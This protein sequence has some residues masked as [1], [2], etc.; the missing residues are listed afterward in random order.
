V[1]IS[2]DGKRVILEARGDLFFIDPEKKL[3]RNLTDTPGTTE[4]SPRWS[5]NGKYYAYI[6]D[7]SG[8]EQIYVCEI[9]QNSKSSRRLTDC[10][11]T[12][13]AYISWS[14]D[15]KTIG[16]SSHRSTYF[17]TEVA[18]TVSRKVFF[19]KYHGSD[20]YVSAAWSPDSRWLAFSKANNQSWF[21][22]I[23]LY[24]LETGKT[25]RVTGDFTHDDS[26]RFDPRGR[27]LFW[28]TG[29]DVNVESSYWDSNHF[30]VNPSKIIAAAL[31]KDTFAPFTQQEGKAG[32]NKKNASPLQIDIDGLGERMT[33]L[34]VKNAVLTNLIA[35]K[36]KLIYNSA[37]FREEAAI[38]MFDMAAKKESILMKN[39]RYCIPAANGDKIIYRAGNKIGLLEI[40]PNQK[41]GDGALDFSDLKATV[42]Y[43]KSW[44]HIFDE[45]WRIQRDTF[46]DENINGVDWEAVKKRYDTLVP[47]ITTRKELNHLIERMFAE[48]GHSHVELYGGDESEIS[49]EK[50]GSLGIDL[51]WDTAKRRYRIAKIYRGQNWNPH[52]ISPLTLPG[53]NVKE[54]DYLLSIDGTILK[55]NVNPFSLLVN[56]AGKTVSLKI[57]SKPSPKDSRTLK[58][59]PV[60]LE[61]RELNFLRYNDWVLSNIEK[62]NRASGGK[63]GY[64]HIPDTYLAGI[65]AFFRYFHP[66]I[67]KQAL[68]VD[69]RYNSGGYAPFWMIERLNRKIIFNWHLPH[70]K[71]SERSPDP[72]CPGPKV[73]IANEWAESGGDMFVE[74]FRQ[75]NAGLIIGKRTAGSLASTSGYYLMDKGIVISP[76]KGPFNSR[77]KFFIENIGV[78][79]DIEVTNH[80]DEMLNGSDAQLERGIQELLK[81][82]KEKKPSN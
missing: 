57:H 11:K 6:S 81:Q 31:Q 63:I 20:R 12:R 49:K 56:K 7:V 39:A 74:S 34:P 71:A 27:Y 35:T 30:M 62:V 22:S 68:I 1:T 41:V 65:E 17:I 82:L 80:P 42:D 50:N 79:P 59:K 47:F 21:G 70:G 25:H 9:G 18:T 10:D 32:T 75:L 64:I 43:K 40:K 55:K 38:R 76:S 78:S 51:G 2:P 15:S 36:D 67:H 54:G 13:F 53:M 28:I 61:E 44:K 14:P 72:L 19:N 46:W 16:Y 48:L 73:C 69:V 66:Q 8:E 52:R 29:H 58:V 4:K 5:P 3:T 26:P 24:S 45:A 77:G 37:P 23:Y 33:S 60:L